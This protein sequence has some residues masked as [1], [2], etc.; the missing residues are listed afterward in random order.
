MTS[1]RSRSRVLF[2]VLPD[3]SARVTLGIRPTARDVNDAIVRPR[4]HGP[5]TRTCAITPLLRNTFRLLRDVRIAR[6][7]L[8]A[9]QRRYL[10]F[11]SQTE[12]G[13]RQ[14]S[15]E[16]FYR[17]RL[18]DKSPRARVRIIYI[19]IVS[20]LSLSLAR[21]PRFNIPPIRSVSGIFQSRRSRVFLT[22]TNPKPY[23]FLFFSSSFDAY[24]TFY[25]II[26]IISLNSY[27]GK[28]IR[29]YTYSCRYDDRRR[30]ALATDD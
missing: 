30:Y 8:L 25:I 22:P 13:H 9:R 26:I 21:S 6:T 23:G 10:F 12:P 11:A 24:T 1:A 3:R 4:V 20:P 27:L 19:I 14:I 28:V 15:S 5:R 7:R 16:C 29:R 17:F 18:S 2:V